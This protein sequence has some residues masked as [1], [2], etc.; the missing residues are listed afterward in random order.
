MRKRKVLSQDNVWGYLMIAPTIIG[1]LILNVYPF[2]NTVVLIFCK[3]G[4]FGG[5]SC[6][7]LDY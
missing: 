4:V 7:G 3:I 1:L 6:V 5:Q 2:I